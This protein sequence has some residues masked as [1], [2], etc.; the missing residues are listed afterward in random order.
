MIIDLFWYLDR[1]A[2]EMAENNEDKPQPS[3][4]SNN[5]NISAK[6]VPHSS[7]EIA[8]GSPR[9]GFIPGKFFCIS[10]LDYT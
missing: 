7:D 9:L 6:N 2:A 8:A 5:L 1:S 10:R 4:K 3:G